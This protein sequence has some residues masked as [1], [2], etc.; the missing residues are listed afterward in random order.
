MGGAMGGIVSTFI[1]KAIFGIWD[2]SMGLNGVLAGLVSVTANCH[3]TEPWHAII[4]GAVGGVVLIIGHFL[5]KKIR[6]D[7]PCDAAVVHGLCG[8]WG[9]WAS[10]IFCVD[11]WHCIV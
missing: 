10:G 8:T 5:L 6:V 1:G 3:I 11:R 7:D 2:I 4:I 9:L